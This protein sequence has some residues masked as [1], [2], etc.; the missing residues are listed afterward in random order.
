MIWVAILLLAA[1]ALA[2]LS[3]PLWRRTPLMGR[4]SATLDL[5]RAQLAELDRDLAESRIGPA[6]HA[7]AVLEVQRR[8]LAAAATED[9]VLRP[10]S[11]VPLIAALVVIPIAAIGLYMVGGRPNLPGAPLAERMAEADERG[12]S[13]AALM[14]QLRATL[15]KLDPHSDQARQGFELLGNILAAEGDD[16]D[17]VEAWRK[18]LAVRFDPLLAART[19]D[20]TARADGRLT[21]ASA[22]LFRR[23]LAAAPP[24]APWRA[25]VE[26][27]LAAAPKP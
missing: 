3:L 19:A 10:S 13:A 17:A 2:P 9:V 8:L 26:Q 25:Q 15:A 16:R 14:Q 4:Q 27:R 12:T 18:A 21:D 20:A 1:L 24:D 5:H 7:T 6:E 11:P 22:T 23:A